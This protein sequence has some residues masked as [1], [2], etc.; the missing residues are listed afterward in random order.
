ME[1]D[2][3]VKKCKIQFHSAILL[4][5]RNLLLSNWAPCLHSNHIQ[6]FYMQKCSITVSLRTRRKKELGFSYHSVIWYLDA[7]TNHLQDSDFVRLQ[8]QGCFL[9]MLLPEERMDLD[10][11]WTLKSPHRITR[12]VWGSCVDCEQNKYRKAIWSWQDRET[13][14]KRGIICILAEVMTPLRSVTGIWAYFISEQLVPGPVDWEP[15]SWWSRP[16]DPGE[17]SFRLISS[18]KNPSVLHT[19]HKHQGRAL[20]SLFRSTHPIQT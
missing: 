7:W 20:G 8:W 9:N 10:N 5:T 14:L 19:A 15:I 12:N 1:L 3:P 13:T 6:L 16:G 4:C 17:F 18:K 11:S 2:I